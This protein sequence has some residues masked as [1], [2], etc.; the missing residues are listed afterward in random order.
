MKENTFNPTEFITSLKDTYGYGIST[1]VV[2][3]FG[4]WYAARL[5]WKYICD[6]VNKNS[7]KLLYPGIEVLLWQYLS[8]WDEIESKQE[9]PI[10]GFHGRTGVDPQYSAI[11]AIRILTTAFSLLLQ[12]TPKA[13]EKLSAA[14]KN[15]A[16]SSSS[17]SLYFLIHE[18]EARSVLQ[19]EGFKDNIPYPLAIEN[20][21]FEGSNQIANEVI[22]LLLE[23]NITAIRVFDIVHYLLEKP[24]S[25]IDPA[26]EWDEMLQVLDSLGP[27]IVHISLG[28]N[29]HDSLPVEI[30]TN[31]MWEKLAKTLQNKSRYIVIEYQR[32]SFLD[33]LWSVPL[34]DEAF[35]ERTIKI[36]SL[37]KH[38]KII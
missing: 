9:I 36:F 14:K 29:S 7:N 18:T 23:L 31:Q 15:L 35:V 27:C 22:T 37:L 10:A 34:K 4:D 28:T 1:D 19:N 5:F 16:N 32:S 17:R 13:L 26:S 11:S 20:N 21:P 8:P 30:I 25:L 38:Y 6:E 24:N 12:S 2:G 33:K 3:I